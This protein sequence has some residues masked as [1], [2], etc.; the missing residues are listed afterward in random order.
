M[1]AALLG[2]VTAPAVLLAPVAAAHSVLISVDPEDGSQ[3]DAAPEQIVL[4]FNEEVNQNF[5]SVAVT[6]GDDRTNRVTGEPMV[7][8]ETVTARVDDLAPGAYTVGYRVTSADG[9]VVSGSSVFTV[10]GAEGGAGAGEAGGEGGA[11]GGEGGAGAEGS[12]AGGA[13]A[14]DAGGESADADATEADVADETSGES[15]GVNPVIWAVGGLAVLLIGGAFVL[16]RRG[17]GS[18]S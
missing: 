9:H 4:T 7:D 15:S 8:G 14:A 5:A 6:A 10:A 13:T 2:G 17:R 18:G 16:L 11:A 12:A 1:A 3:L